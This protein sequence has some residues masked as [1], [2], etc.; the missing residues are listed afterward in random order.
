MPKD[1][2]FQ[3]RNMSQSNDPIGPQSTQ[4]KRYASI[5][6]IKGDKTEDGHYKFVNVQ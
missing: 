6:I 3:K 1:F 2:N 4:A 5:D